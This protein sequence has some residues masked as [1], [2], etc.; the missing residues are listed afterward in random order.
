MTYKKSHINPIKY[1]CE[2]CNYNTYNKKDY[3]KHLLTDKH[4]YLQNT[5]ENPQ[6]SHI[7]NIL[8]YIIYIHYNPEISYKT[9]NE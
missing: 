6:K 2:I 9:R 4:K 8:L 5:S 1:S 7:N 3:N